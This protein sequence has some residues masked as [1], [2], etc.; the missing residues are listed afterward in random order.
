MTDK[1]QIAPGPRGHWLMGIIPDFRQDVLGFLVNSSQSHG[2]VV[3]F[4]IGP[5]IFHLVNHPDLI[6]QVLQ[7]N[8]DN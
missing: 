7:G 2:D 5:F 1:A 8:R 4:K 6:R 3:R